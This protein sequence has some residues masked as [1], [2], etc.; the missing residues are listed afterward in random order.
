M[1]DDCNAT[2]EGPLSNGC[3]VGLPLQARRRRWGAVSYG[4]GNPGPEWLGRRRLRSETLQRFCSGERTPRRT[5]APEPG[6]LCICDLLQPEDNDS[7]EGRRAVL[8]PR[9]RGPGLPV[10]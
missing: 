6:A 8:P 3:G 2:L 7:G 9:V 5:K 1:S 4:G 10:N